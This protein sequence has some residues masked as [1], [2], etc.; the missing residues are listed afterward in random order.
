MKNSLVFKQSKLLITSALVTLSLLTTSCGSGDS[1]KN[2]DIPGVDG[3]TVVLLQDDI[4]IDIVLENVQVEGGARFNIPNYT[5]SYV[6]IAPD[7]QSNGTLLAFSVSLDDIFGGKADRLDPLTLPGGR[8]I[9]GVSGGALPA[10]AFSVPSIKNIAFYIGP[11]IFG[12]WV[13][14][15]GLNMSGAMLTTRFYTD[16]KRVGNLSLVGEDANGENGGFFLALTVS[17]SEE[18][19]L[20]RMADR[21]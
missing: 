13:P 20:E 14:V 1:S 3:P 6:E 11:Q 19:Y 10:V 4:L 16:S 18:R 21:Y 12:V 8:A 17:R 15:N 2:L 5:N 7:L 9:P